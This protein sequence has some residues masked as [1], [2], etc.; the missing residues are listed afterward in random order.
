LSEREIEIIKL[1]SKGLTS[2][3]IADRL[4][5]SKLTIDTHKKNIFKKCSVKNSAG[6]VMKAL[7]MKILKLS[8]L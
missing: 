1:I 2:K 7:D 3:E 5:L 6:L 8:V 4:A